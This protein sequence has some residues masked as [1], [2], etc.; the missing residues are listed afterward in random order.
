[1][2]LLLGGGEVGVCGMHGF[3]EFGGWLVFGAGCMDAVGFFHL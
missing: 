3:V 2:L 1:M